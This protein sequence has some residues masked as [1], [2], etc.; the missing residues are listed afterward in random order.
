MNA[1]LGSSDNA[2]VGKRLLKKLKVSSVDAIAAQSDQ[3]LERVVFESLDYYAARLN[4]IIQLP[5]PS[6]ADFAKLKQ[7]SNDKFGL[8]ACWQ[9]LLYSPVS[10]DAHSVSIAESE[11]IGMLKGCIQDNPNYSIYHGE[12][13][14]LDQYGNLYHGDWV[15][16]VNQGFGIFRGATGFVFVGQ[17]EHDQMVDGMR[18]VRG[19]HS[20]TMIT[21]GEPDKS[22]FKPRL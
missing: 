19:L 5:P 3:Q 14:L 18:T 9:R 13:A 1:G 22:Y 16:S 11:Y 7:L 21:A 10:D 15:D 17:W 4:Y 2:R 20:F 8:R 12:G 6:H